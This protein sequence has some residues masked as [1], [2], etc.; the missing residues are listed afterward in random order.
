[1]SIHAIAYVS[2][3]RER[4]MSPE[5]MDRL[6]VEAREFNLAWGVTGVL[7][8]HDGNFL[9]YIEGP[10]DAVGLVFQRIQKA[11][12]HHGIVEL[13][14][15]P[16]GQRHFSTWTMGFAEAGRTD[17]Q[18]ISQAV[19]CEQLQQINR[20]P[21]NSPG[22]ALLMAFWERIAPRSLTTSAGERAD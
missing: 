16:V 3:A 7:L 9:Q 17:L 6:L 15:G 12:R 5:A 19:W 1:M 21:V 14:N 11:S 2:T 18:R 8:H 13:L 20:E 22:L 4:A 10:A